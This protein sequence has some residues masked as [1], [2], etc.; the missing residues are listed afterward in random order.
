MYVCVLG[1]GGEGKAAEKGD[2]MS[3]TWTEGMAVKEVW[4]WV[5]GRGGCGGEINI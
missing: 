1:E 3:R 2:G 5:E 4:G